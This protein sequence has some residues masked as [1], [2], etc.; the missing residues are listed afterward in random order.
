MA[1]TILILHSFH[2]IWFFNPLAFIRNMS[3]L[4]DKLSGIGL[5]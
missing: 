5:K 1:I 2:H 4:L 3:A